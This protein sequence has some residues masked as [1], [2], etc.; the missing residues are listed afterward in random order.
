MDAGHLI[1]INFTFLYIIFGPLVLF[2]IYVMFD[3]FAKLDEFEIGQ[4]DHAPGVKDPALWTSE[5]INA[6]INRI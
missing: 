4:S 2:A 6:Y 1:A 5:D 3:Y